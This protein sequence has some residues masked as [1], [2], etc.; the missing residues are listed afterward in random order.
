MRKIRK[1]NGEDGSKVSDENLN[2]LREDMTARMARLADESVDSSRVLET[3]TAASTSRSMAPAA[4]PKAEP[5]AEPVTPVAAAPKT[6]PAIVTLQ[7]LNAFKAKYGADKDLTDYR[8]AQAG[9][10]KRRNAPPPKVRETTVEDVFPVL[11]GE[12]KRAE[13]KMDKKQFRAEQNAQIIARE[14]ARAKAKAAEEK[15]TMKKRSDS[16]RETQSK[17]VNER[18][19]DLFKVK[20]SEKKTPKRSGNLTDMLGLSSRYASGGSVSSRADGIA[21]R[22]KTRGKMC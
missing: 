2:K 21:Q 19:K 22:G 11:T 18:F 7:Q 17:P 4:E 5:E 10:L 15:E 12:K 14:A 20:E 8:N 13:E 9:G 3:P 16:D 1:F 6:K